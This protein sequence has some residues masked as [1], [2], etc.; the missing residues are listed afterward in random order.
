MAKTDKKPLNHVKPLNLALQ[1]GGS[2]GA[3]T[4]GV[5]DRLLE[6]ERLQIEA[7]TATSAGAVN[8]A[9]LISAYAQG[10]GG[11]NGRALAREK[12]HQLWYKVS[13]A[14]SLLQV[15]PSMVEK[16]F[17]PKNLDYSPSF[18]AADF[19]MR[20]FS[21]Y[22]FNMFDI[23]PLRGIVEELV[24]FHKLREQKAIK[25]FVNATHVRTGKSKVFNGAEM[26]LDMIMASAC[27]P[28]LFKTVE[29]HGE[30]YWDGGYSG[31]PALFPLFY[32][33]RSQDIVLVQIN[34]LE[35]EAV[36]TSAPEILDRVNEISFNAGLMSEVRA[37]MFV[38]KLLEEG[39]VSSQN[40]KNIH[41]HLVEAQELLSPLGRSSKF[42][43]DWNFFQHLRDVGRQSAADWL[44]AHYD[45]IGKHSS[46]NIQGVFL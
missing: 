30:P 25:F 22:Q 3:F 42:N 36:P 19:L 46:V 9:V 43:A 4:W 23:N 2:H 44:D 34:P 12:L 24:D 35:V 31:N 1:G 40:Y 38:K 8:G 27:L 29:V 32:H 16:I 17:T 39:D 15:K 10:G 20:V 11:A 28:F 26:N 21:P 13:K 18:V 6:D 14:A 5:L 33:S 41:L 45:N 7:V 37:I